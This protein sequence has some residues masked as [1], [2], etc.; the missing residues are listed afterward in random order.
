MIKDA[1]KK[2]H[3]AAI[4]FIADIRNREKQ[5]IEELQ[6]IYGQDCMEQI[7][8]KKDLSA[9]V[10][11]LRSTCNLTEV[12]LQ[13]KD[14]ELL[15]LK[16]EVQEKLNALSSVEIKNLPNTVNKKIN[17]SAGSIDFGFIQD[18]DRPLASRMRVKKQMNSAEA[19]EWPTF[20]EKTTQTD[21]VD[22]KSQAKKNSNQAMSDSEEDSDEES[23][24]SE[25][26]SEEEGEKPE[27]VDSGVQTE[28]HDSSSSDESDSSDDEDSAPEM[29]DEAMMTELI[30]TAEIGVNTRSRC[31]GQN[32]RAGS[33]A[34]DSGE[35]NSLAARR[36]RRRER[37]Q[38]TI[39][40]GST[41]EAADDTDDNANTNTVPRKS[42]MSRLIAS[43]TSLDGDDQYYDTSSRPMK[44][45]V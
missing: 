25:E 12:I 20:T 1:E 27:L 31:L 2:I 39:L 40:P 10:D 15:L 18:L 26:E 32:Q 28:Q 42:R 43:S 6:N 44:N 22:P 21:L 38:S 13:G 7:Q 34:E 17:Y 24:D 3:D 33:R 19:A 41:E 35:D 5:L 8:N 36:R 23:G 11:S 9:Q 37:A 4:Q 30:E 14:I 16:K 45:Y 29:K